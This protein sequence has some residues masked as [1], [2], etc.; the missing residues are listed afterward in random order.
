MNFFHKNPEAKPL[1][2]IATA[3]EQ[4]PFTETENNQGFQA[5]VKA[6]RGKK[7]W[8][9]YLIAVLCIGIAVV[10]IYYYQKNKQSADCKNS[11]SY[12]YYTVTK[13]DLVSSISSSGALLPADSY[14]VTTLVSEDYAVMKDYPLQTGRFLE[15]VDILTRQKVCVIGS[16][17]AKEYFNNNIAGETLRI[18]ENTYSI[19]GVLTEKAASAAGSTDDAI[20]LPYSVAAK[21]S[22]TGIN[23]YTVA[24]TSQNTVSQAK[25]LV[26]DALY[27]VFS[28]DKAYRVVSMAEMLS[29]MTSMVNIVVLI[30]G[31]IA[32]ISLVVGGIGIMNIMLVSVS[33]RTKEIGI[34][35][36]LGAKQRNIME[37]FVIEAG[38]T[39]GFGGLIGI[40]LGYTL[41][42]LG[43][44][45]ISSVAAT[46]IVITPSTSS[47]LT[48]F[49]VSVTIGIVFGYLPARKAAQLNPIEA[50][51]YD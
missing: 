2:E 33:E 14:K 4:L 1:Q 15:Y 26:E 28:S 13:Q 21:L 16:Y 9:I 19:I 43:S 24:V 48:A 5:A 29:T 32:A 8:P 6:K 30:L 45:V 50:L 38:T 20:Y 42:S 10:S 35:K 36:A 51:R 44:K 40:V 49:A 47:V 18:G 31:A 12:T 25:K 34:R 46:D 3:D 23:T 39:S 27:K 7:K 41:S 17:L 22:K 37:Q 11:V